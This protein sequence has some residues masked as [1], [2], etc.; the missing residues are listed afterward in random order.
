[1]KKWQYVCVCV[2]ERGRKRSAEEGCENNKPTL[3]YELLE[4]LIVHSTRPIPRRITRWHVAA[5]GIALKLRRF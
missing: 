2:R 3:V 4:I 5:V 1:M